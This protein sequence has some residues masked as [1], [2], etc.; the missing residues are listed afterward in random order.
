M[1]FTK[2]FHIIPANK[3]LLKSSKVRKWLS[4][5]EDAIIAFMEQEGTAWWLDDVANDNRR[6][7]DAGQ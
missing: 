2:P 1:K 7:P 6:R 5:S 3:E 4:D